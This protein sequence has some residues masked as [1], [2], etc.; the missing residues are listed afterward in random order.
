M[1]TSSDEP[2]GAVDEEIMRLLW[3]WRRGPSRL[4]TLVVLPAI[5]GFLST[6]RGPPRLQHI[7]GFPAPN[8][9][10]LQIPRTREFHAESERAFEAPDSDGVPST[11]VSFPPLV[12]GPSKHQTSTV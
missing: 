10:S 3:A 8:I 12:G 5:V 7:D 9:D 1:R 2:E 11:S 4:C 6:L